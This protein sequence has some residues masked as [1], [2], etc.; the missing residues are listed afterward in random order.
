MM[1]INTTLQKR[2]DA[3]QGRHLASFLC[4][5]LAPKGEKA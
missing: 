2:G 3:F 5:R 4:E 1:N